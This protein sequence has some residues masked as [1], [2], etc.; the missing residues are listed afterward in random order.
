MPYYGSAVILTVSV[1]E[2]HS[3]SLEFQAQEAEWVEGTAV[4]V[5]VMVVVG[6]EAGSIVLAVVDSLVVHLVEVRTLVE[7][8]GARIAVVGVGRMGFSGQELDVLGYEC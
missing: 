1:V 6:R 5:A 8:G 3:A 7:E 4:V 2:E